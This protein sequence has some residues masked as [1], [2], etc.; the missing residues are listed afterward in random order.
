[1]IPRPDT[2]VPNSS[3]GRCTLHHR[4]RA[5]QTHLYAAASLEPNLPKTSRTP[6]SKSCWSPLRVAGRIAATHTH[7]HTHMCLRAH[8]HAHAHPTCAYVHTCTHTRTHSHLL[9]PL[10]FRYSITKAAPPPGR[11]NTL[12]GRGALTRPVLRRA[13]RLASSPSNICRACTRTHQEL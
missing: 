5:V 9:K 13:S 4:Q 2:T 6:E 10:I 12:M 8:T 1:M 7:T 3:W 11:L